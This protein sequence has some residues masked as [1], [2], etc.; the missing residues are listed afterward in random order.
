MVGTS[1]SACERV[2]VETASARSFPSLISGTAGAVDPKEI[3]VWP[4]TAEATAGPP[5]LNGTCTRSR[6][7]DRRNNSPTRCGGVP[8]PGEAKLYLPGLVLIRATRS[9]TVC[10]GS[11]GLT[12][13]TTAARTATVT[14]SKFL[15]GSYGTWW[16]RAGLTTR[17][18]PVT[19]IV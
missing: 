6:P 11:V 5:P 2:L 9:A 4:A 17:L 12:V 3:G 15:A 10:T 16:Y 1:G 7:S 13:S 18:A 8:V 14:A 19:R